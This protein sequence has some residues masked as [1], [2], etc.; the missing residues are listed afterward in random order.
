MP[1]VPL[2]ARFLSGSRRAIGDFRHRDNVPVLEVRARRENSLPGIRPAR[3]NWLSRTMTSSARRAP[4]IQ[5]MTVP[6][7]TGTLLQPRPIGPVERG[8]D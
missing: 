3:S 8:Q 6:L 4:A 7:Q 2:V 1:Q 5:W